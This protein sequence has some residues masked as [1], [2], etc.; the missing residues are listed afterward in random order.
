MGV[1]KIESRADVGVASGEWSGRRVTFGGLFL[2]C[3]SV[4][5][6]CNPLLLWGLNIFD[7]NPQWNGKIR[8]AEE[9]P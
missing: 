8:R 9:I 1:S 3:L 7:V 4:A 2:Q 5:C 6:A